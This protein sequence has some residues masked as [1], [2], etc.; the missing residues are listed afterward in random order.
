MQGT[1]YFVEPTNCGKGQ[2]LTV[3]VAGG[4]CDAEEQEAPAKPAKPAREAATAPAP[5][6]AE[7]KADAASYGRGGMGGGGGEYGG[8]MRGGS[9]GWGKGRGHGHG[10]H[11]RHGH[12][13]DGDEGGWDDEGSYGDDDEDW[14]D[15][16]HGKGGDDGPRK[17]PKGGPKDPVE[18]TET[19]TPAPAAAP[20]PAPAVAEAPLLAPAGAPAPEAA[21]APVEVGGCAG[22]GSTCGVWGGLP[23]REQPCGLVRSERSHPLPKR[24]K[25]APLPTSLSARPPPPRRAMLKPLR[26]LALRL[27]SL[28]TVALRPPLRPPPLRR[29]RPMRRRWL[30]Q[31]RLRLRQSLLRCPGR[32]LLMR[33]RSRRRHLPSRPSLL[34]GSR[35]ADAWRPAPLPPPPCLLSH[36][37]Q[38]RR[39]RMRGLLHATRPLRRWAAQLGC[40][41]L[42]WLEGAQAARHLPQAHPLAHS[43]S[44]S[45]SP[46]LQAFFDPM[47]M[48]LA[49]A[50]LGADLE[51]AGAEQPPSGKVGAASATTALPCGK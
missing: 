35:A 48:M 1:F 38:R 31:A 25:L 4:T 51:L 19:P 11:S 34:C 12:G 40:R 15:D 8:S 27:P 50:G 9:G 24:L 36:R 41:W 18:P 45:P 37:R 5:A 32:L 26:P 28:P 2:V 20:A 30:S 43:L 16:G 13:D 49:A 6:P 33:S 46:S 17:P 29:A 14:G 39:W 23:E 44:V 21:E 3:V 7:E 42:L 47:D 10:G 22:V